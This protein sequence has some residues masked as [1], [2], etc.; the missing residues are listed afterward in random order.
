MLRSLILLLGFNLL[1]FVECILDVVGLNVGLVR[2]VYKP[3]DQAHYEGIKFLEPFNGPVLVLGQDDYRHDAVVLTGPTREMRKGRECDCLE[4]FQPGEVMNHVPRRLGQVRHHGGSFAAIKS[5]RNEMI[6]KRRH[7]IVCPSVIFRPL[8]R[9]ASH[10]ELMTQGEIPLAPLPIESADEVGHLTGAFNRLLHKSLA[11]QAEL[12]RVASHDVLTGLP[13]RLLLSDRM[14][15]TLARSKR[16]RTT[17]AVLFLDLDEF[18]PI[19]DRLGHAAGDDALVQVTQRLT[20]IMREEDTL[21]RV[22]GDEFVVVISDLDPVAEKAESAACV[23]ATKCIEAINSPM[24]I[25]GEQLSVGIS[26]G[27]AMGDSESSFDELLSTADS[28]MYRAKQ[29]GR[30]RYALADRIA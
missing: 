4:V 9:A 3:R 1:Q 13:N 7:R 12:V 29:S 19:N 2:D 26:I 14:S 5:L 10:A 25:K 27:I 28:A 11:S 18:K 22:G 24:T 8:F 20:A 21:A 30:W 23:V 15:Q 6:A 17:L 16:N